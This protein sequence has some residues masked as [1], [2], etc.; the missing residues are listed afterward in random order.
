MATTRLTT[1][2]WT[3]TAFAAIVAVLIVIGLYYAMAQYLR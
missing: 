1:P 2:P 3:W